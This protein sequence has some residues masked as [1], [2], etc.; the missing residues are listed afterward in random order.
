MKQACDMRSHN[1]KSP[2]FRSFLITLAYA[3]FGYAWIVGSELFVA[4]TLHESLNVFKI[5][6]IK[7]IA[8][9]TATAI[10]I[11][12]LVYTNLRKVHLESAIR[13]ESED[14]LKE[15]Q[16]LAHVGNFSY[17]AKTGVY[18][19][20]DE[21]INILDLNDNDKP[22]TYDLLM[23]KVQIGDRERVYAMTTELAYNAGG[24]LAFDCRILRAH[25]SERTVQVRLQVLIQESNKKPFIFGTLQDVT[26]R[27]QAEAAARENEAIYKALLNSSYDL[28]Y[29][30]D[31]ALRYVAVNTN[32]QRY[33]GILE[34]DLIGKQ[35]HAGQVWRAP[36]FFGQ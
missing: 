10:L 5:S 35:L 20:S 28:V 21:A 1:Q 36:G 9:V 16:H 23:R 31:S 19:F 4:G 30:K 7:G 6:I 8:F 25:E 15:A 27:A 17:N 34:K 12:I 24:E 26:E 2:Q 3:I 22:I 14:A 13:K 29:L 11:F 32:M 33:Y 18:T